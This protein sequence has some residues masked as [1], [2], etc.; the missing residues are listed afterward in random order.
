MARPLKVVAH[1]H[2]YPPDHNAGAEWMIHSILARLVDRHNVDARVIVSRPPRR[3]RA[4][5]GVKVEMIRDQR[6]AAVRYRWA[7]VAITHLDATSLA[8][9]QARRMSTPLVHL[10]HNDQQL[11]RNHGEKLCQGIIW[12]STW[13]R[14]ATQR[15]PDAPSIVVYPPVWCDR[16]EVET[17]GNAVTLVNL[18]GPKGADVFYQVAKLLPHRSFLGVRGGYGYQVTPPDLANLRVIPNTP[19]I[20]RVW[21]ETAVVVMPSVFESWGRVAVEAAAAGIPC[22]AAPT[23]GLVETG[24]PVAF[25]DVDPADPNEWAEA[26]EELMHDDAYRY[27]KGVEAREQAHAL[28]RRSSR[29]IEQLARWLRAVAGL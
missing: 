13:L 26:I 22:V 12:N 19:D 7:D 16:Y 24:V 1:V 25:A 9:H 8:M 14:D 20:R 15:V 2:G 3:N 11:T 6:R 23:P 29:Q 5:E 27:S 28:E 4:F 17:T 21:R 10:V 18:Y